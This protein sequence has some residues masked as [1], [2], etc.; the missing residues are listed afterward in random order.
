MGQID[1]K[2]CIQQLILSATTMALLIRV[3]AVS[4]GSELVFSGRGG[5]KTR[6]PWNNW[7]LEKPTLVKW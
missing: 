1:I 4:C 3:V 5:G 6:L 2:S 7:K